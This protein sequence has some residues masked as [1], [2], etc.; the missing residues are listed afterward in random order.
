[1]RVEVGGRAHYSGSARFTLE[2][3][4]E[5]GKGFLLG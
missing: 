1:V 3:D 2:P 4:D 5:I